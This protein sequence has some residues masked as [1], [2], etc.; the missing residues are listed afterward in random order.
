MA[1]PHVSLTQSLA[2][3]P[4]TLN[5]SKLLELSNLDRQCPL[6]MYLI[7][8]YNPSSIYTNS[9]LDS[10]FTK[11]KIGLEETLSVWSPAAGRLE[12]N[13]ADGKLNLRCDNRGAILAQAV[14]DVKISELGDLSNYNEF[15]EE[16]V[17]KPAL[18]GD[19]CEFPL[20]V[21]QVTRFGC[22]GYSIGTGISH[23]LFDGPAA[24]E[25]LSAWATKSAIFKDDK[26]QY[27]VE[28]QKPVHERGRL[29]M[30]SV[31]NRCSGKRSAAGSGAGAVAIDHLYKLIMQSAMGNEE[32][33]KK[34]YGCRTLRVSRGMIETLKKKAFGENGG[35][36]CSSF[37]VIAA[38]LWKARTKALSV[39]KEKMVCLQFAVDA[40]N[41]L[42][43]PLP[44][45][46]SGNSF[47]LAS[48]ALPA[49]QLE[50]ESYK[51]I[52]EMIRDAK[53]QVDDDYVNA[54]QLGL[55]GPQA[56][57]PPLKELTVIS[58]WTRMPFHKIEFLHGEAAYASPL[59]P[60]ILDVAYFLQ[61]PTDSQAI[62]VR[63]TLL[64]QTLDAFST[65]FLTSMQ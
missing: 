29:L 5:P 19:F 46:F 56:T 16:L 13:P 21:A 32:M 8:F 64:S 4:K 15:F 61:N 31:P 57:L 6:H 35:F 51:T 10:V 14:T 1:T 22:G 36:P 65:Y 37:D 34:E 9:S 18:D 43:P 60:P 47:V 27:G 45:G 33:E 2:V 52:I 59:K 26:E 23:S 30:G 11:L 63:V 55:D 12:P 39:S 58:D 38:H 44:K 40:R 62:D 53:S 48:V 49:K 25:F 17:H 24:Y 50:E 20:V 3:F 41:K 42:K 7:F 28:L 54:Y